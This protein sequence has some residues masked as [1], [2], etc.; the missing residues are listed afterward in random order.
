MGVDSRSSLSSSTPSTSSVVE[1]LS[2]V[3]L[4]RAYFK[5]MLPMFVIDA[6]VDGIVDR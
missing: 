2:V 4:L 5:V 6:G 1:L 3:V